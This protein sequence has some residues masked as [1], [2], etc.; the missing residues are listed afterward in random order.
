MIS[1]GKKSIFQKSQ[2]FQFEAY[3]DIP[4][5]GT[6]VTYLDFFLFEFYRMLLLRYRWNHVEHWNAVEQYLLNK[7]KPI[8]SKL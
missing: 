2:L 4:S 3:H 5:Y 1:S 8:L 6:Y 7:T